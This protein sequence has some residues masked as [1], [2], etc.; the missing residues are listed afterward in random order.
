M[1]QALVQSLLDVIKA[2]FMPVWKER[3]KKKDR[4]FESKSKTPFPF[5]CPYYS[6]LTAW[7]RNHFP[8]MLGLVEE[9]IIQGL[10][11]NAT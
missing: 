1:K 4:G 5:P 7:E 2:E 6:A 11:R 8:R 10:P 9:R 3:K